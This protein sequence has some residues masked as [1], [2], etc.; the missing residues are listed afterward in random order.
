MTKFEVKVKL[1]GD[2]ELII[3]CDTVSYKEAPNAY[4]F[5]WSAGE[6][7]IPQQSMVYFQVKVNADDQGEDEC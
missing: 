4:A 7:V 5:N 1:L 2:K 3:Q 6:V